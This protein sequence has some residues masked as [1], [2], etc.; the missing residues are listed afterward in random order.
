MNDRRKF[1][2]LSALAAGGM[3][4]S[5][6]ALP[7]NREGAEAAPVSAAEMH[8]D[9]PLVISTWRH[10]VAANAAAAVILDAGGRALDAAEA[11]VRVTEADMNVRSVG[12]GGRPDREGRVTLDACI[13]DHDSRCGSVAFLEKIMHPVS[14]ARAV[15]ERTP[16]V[17][18]TGSGAYQFALEQGFE[19]VDFDVP[20]PETTAEWKEWLRESE[21]RPAPNSENHD[22][23]GLLT[24][25]AEGRIAGACTTSGMAYKMHGRVGD[26]PIIGSG[27]F[28][29]GDVGGAVATGLGEAIMRVAGCSAVVE[30]MRAGAT[31]EEA[32]REVAER[33]LRKHPEAEELQA[34]FIA[35]DKEGRFGGYSVL[36]GFNYACTAG[37]ENR[38]IDTRF[39]RSRKEGD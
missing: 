9:G 6:C 16:H 22:T 20:L 4:L 26:S 31:P 28:V 35:V 11:G 2:K 7:E 32:C 21:Y 37:G 29:D 33:I 24:L 8:A 30:Q 39:I 12:L 38:L 18:L 3:A 34:G 10:G 5:R 13:M 17:M 27:L 23:I 1:L 14:V 25:D 36:D 15:M 19:P